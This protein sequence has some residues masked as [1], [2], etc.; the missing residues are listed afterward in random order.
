MRDP[1]RL[2]ISV[3]DRE[4]PGGQKLKPLAEEESEDCANL[5]CARNR[6]SFLYY[7]NCKC[8]FGI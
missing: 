1:G 4:N 6:K 5:Y 8:Y 2:W 3:F 7:A